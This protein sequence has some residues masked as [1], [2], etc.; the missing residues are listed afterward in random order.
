MIWEII[1]KRPRKQLNIQFCSESFAVSFPI[2]TIPYIANKLV[3]NEAYQVLR[4]YDSQSS[5]LI[6]SLNTQNNNN[7]NNN[8]TLNGTV[9]RIQSLQMTR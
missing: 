2:P 7:N 8:K 6:T 5:S 1:R 3:R 9:Q 4:I